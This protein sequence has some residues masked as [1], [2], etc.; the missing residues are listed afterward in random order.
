MKVSRRR[1]RSGFTLLEVLLVIAILGVIAVMVVPQLLG[2]QQQANIDITRTNIKGLEQAL[3]LYAVD[4][5]GEYMQGSRDSLM[6]L[7]ES[8][9]YNGKQLK[10]YLEEDP[11]DA[12]GELLYYE[13]PNTKGGD[14]GK[15][16]IWSSGP[17]RQNE[18]GGGDD[19]ANWTRD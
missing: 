16:A 4:H 3:K 7:L 13:Y 11:N 19:I 12:W 2:R 15:P 6:S 14:S 17:N 18:D 8:S 1:A 5:D 10:P 9:E